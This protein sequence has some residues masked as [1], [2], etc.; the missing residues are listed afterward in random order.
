VSALPSIGR[1][2]R[3]FVV[4]DAAGLLYQ[5]H[6]SR[7]FA[8]C[9]SRLGNREEAEDATQTTFL[10]AF[11]SLQGG[12][13]PRFELAWLFRIAENACRDRRKSAWR[14]GRVEATADLQELQDAVSAPERGD[15]DG[16]VGLNA[17]LAAM[18][19][20]QRRA[21]LLREWQ[22]LSY[23]EIARELDVS[24]AAVETLIFRARRS[25]ARGLEGEAEAPR[26]ARAGL[27]VGW[28]LAAA[29]ALLQGGGAAKLAAS[30]AA[31]ATA[32]L[33]AAVP[34]RDTGAGVPPPRAD[35][36]VPVAPAVPVREETTAARGVAGSTSPERAARRTPVVAAD[37]ARPT[38]ASPRS[39]VRPTAAASK[40]AP[41]LHS[42]PAP[43]P[44]PAPPPKPPP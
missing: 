7:I 30:A 35:G 25:L 15:D 22:G 26:R 18:P 44:A 33:I 37:P 8:F 40:T 31:V 41:P 9:L 20:R 12:V 14:R 17:A 38:P 2:D 42:D 21:I 29:K 19:E 24:N 34:L 11:R 36:S 4:A 32:G 5:R 6:A 3:A 1:A 13:E 16:L 43:T 27:D 39:A 23:D 28:L 10:N